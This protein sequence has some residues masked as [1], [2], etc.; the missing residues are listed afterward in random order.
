M[1]PTQGDSDSGRPEQEILPGDGSAP[2][3]RPTERDHP[4]GGE[5]RA[6]EADCGGEA[7][8]AYGASQ[9]PGPAGARL[10]LGEVKQSSASKP[11]LVFRGVD[12]AQPA[13]LVRIHAL[14]C[15][16]SAVRDFTVMDLCEMLASFRSR[17]ATLGITGT[18]L[19][20]DLTFMQI[21][22]GEEAAVR[23][24]FARIAK[25]PRHTGVMTLMDEEVPERA[26][27]EWSMAFPIFGSLG[28]RDLPGFRDFRK[29]PLQEPASHPPSR[30]V[31]FLLTFQR[32]LANEG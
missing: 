1:R 31:K 10:I 7:P 20:H 25:D 28:V 29:A 32:L 30:A 14:V 18:L 22:E 6:R 9:A 8:S 5:G 24:L 27:P 17:N 2:G 26:F 19:Y 16:S 3:G 23:T 21:L 4:R 12:S 13:S 11:P 15:I